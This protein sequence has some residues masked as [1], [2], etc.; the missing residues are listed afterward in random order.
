MSFP[1]DFLWGVAASSFQNEGAAFEEGKG[2]SIWDMMARW[3]GKISRGDTPDPGCDQYHRYREDAQ[4][5]REIGI[6]AYRLSVAWP[7]VLPEGSGAPNE[8]GLA[9]YDRLIDTLLENQVE[10]WVSLY[11]W[12]YPYALHLRGGWLN[13]DSS[14]WFADYSAVVVDR[15][16]DRVTYWETVNEPQVFIGAGYRDGTLPPGLKLD[17]PEVLL[18]AHHVLLSHGKAV[19]VIRARA[20]RQ[21]RVGAVL[22]GFVG[23]P[24]TSSPQ[25]I[26]AARDYMFTMTGGRLANTWLAFRNTWLADP[27]YFGRYPED[28]VMLQGKAMPKIQSGDM[29]IIS[30]PL[31]YYGVNIYGGETVRASASGAPEVVPAP[32]GPPLTAL[33]WGVTPEALYWGPRLFYE[34]YKLPIFITENGMAGCDWVHLDGRVHDPQRIDFLTRYLRELG[35]AVDEG[36]NVSGYFIW[37]FTDNFECA[38]GYKAR[39]GIVYIDYATQKRVLKDSAYWYRDV[40]ATNGAVLVK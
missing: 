21:P 28:G 10:P 17:N 35:R 39:F 1:K 30:Q 16:S 33:E 38:Q 18:V 4:L 14:D 27:L 37:T 2:P 5:M 20:R 19:Q 32:L 26:Q 34:R 9:F 29:E 7:R 3:E 6:K 22:V 13:P 11:H 25:D 12:D 15:L 31:D 40:I 8:K 24:A 36:V 23:I